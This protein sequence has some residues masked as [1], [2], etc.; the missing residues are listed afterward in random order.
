[1]EDKLIMYIFVNKDLGMSAGK[2]ASQVG[3]IVHK[4]VD[5]ILNNAYENLI[6]DE[7]YLNYLKWNKDCIKIVLKASEDDLREL[8][9]LKNAKYFIDSKSTQV[10]DNS[11]TVVG[12]PPCSNMYKI[13]EKYYLL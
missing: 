2:I 6:S 7:N 13:A 9:K 3:H 1:M 8:L 10:E 12:F 5:E 4:I 11:L